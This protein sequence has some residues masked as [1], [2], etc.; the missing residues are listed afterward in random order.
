MKIINICPYCEKNDFSVND[1]NKT[2]VLCNNCKKE[3]LVDD[4]KILS[5]KDYPDDKYEVK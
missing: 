4:L 5:I 3:I 2:K 1:K